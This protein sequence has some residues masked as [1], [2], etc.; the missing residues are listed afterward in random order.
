MFAD[1]IVWFRFRFCP[2]PVFGFAKN[3]LEYIVQAPL[4]YTTTK[5]PKI[6]EQLERVG[7]KHKV[8]IFLY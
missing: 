2:Q 7:A 3:Y 5:I 6:L 1:A 8:I 4:W